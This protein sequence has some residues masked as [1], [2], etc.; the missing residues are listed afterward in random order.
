MRTYNDVYLDT[1]KKL[2]ENGVEAYALEARL[3]VSAAAGKTQAALVRD[4][5]LY[6]T[7]GFEAKMGDYIERRLAGEPVAYITG[8]WEFYGLM[9]EI[10]PD[11]L[12]PRTDTELLAQKAIE[13][14]RGRGSSKRVLDLC[15]GS[16]CIGITVGAYVPDS[17]VIMIDKSLKALAVSRSN[18]YKNNL[19]RTITCVDADA[20]ENPPMLIGRFDLITCN[21]PYI[22]SED[23]IG[24]D[25]SVRDYEPMS[26]LDGG[27]DG[28]IFYREI[29]KKWKTVLKANGCLLFEVGIGQAEDVKTIMQENG[30]E[31]IVVFKDTAGI[32][33]V[34]AG[35]YPEKTSMD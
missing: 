16:G 18:V 29:T 9:F 11:V 20:L 35:L 33:R 3:L 27:A 25:V 34:V 30:F 7:D 2:R 15:C 13:L 26:A 14:L 31:S 28:L 22:P 19:V 10:T 17:R 4:F 21:P 8:E 1:R 5:G 32:D 6:V 23:I 24:L 12:I